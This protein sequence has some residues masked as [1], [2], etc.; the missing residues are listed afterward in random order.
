MRRV[1]LRYEADFTRRLAG[2]VD[3]QMKFNEWM[4]GERFGQNAAC[5][6][7]ADG[8]DK[9]A[10]RTK[11]YEVSRDVARPAD[12][13]FRPFDRNHG[14]GRFRRNPRDLAIDKLIQHEIADAE[15]GLFGE[16]NK[17]FVKIVHGA[18]GSGLDD[19][20]NR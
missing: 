17:M 13:H 1:M 8:T 6:V 20:D 4:R 5:V 3:N 10:A 16:R 18:I 7:I 2:T 9:D 15:H 19:R 12:H 11:G 14:G